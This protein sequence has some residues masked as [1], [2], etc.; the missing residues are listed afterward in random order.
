MQAVSTVPYAYGRIRIVAAAI[1]ILGYS[2]AYR[3]AL[4]SREPMP[5][6]PARAF[7]SPARIGSVRQRVLPAAPFA[8]WPSTSATRVSIGA[9][10]SSSPTC[11]ASIAPGTPTAAGTPRFQH[12]VCRATIGVLRYSRMSWRSARIK[13]TL[14]TRPAWAVPRTP[15]LPIAATAILTASCGIVGHG[16]RRASAARTTTTT[17][18]TVASR[19]PGHRVLWST[20]RWRSGYAPSSARASAYI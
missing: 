20:W 9:S 3:R 17:R 7:A 11:I 5:P 1:Q 16:V 15:A 18:S 6:T 2:D 13:V 14:M 12:S 19:A 4:R 8:T 10:S